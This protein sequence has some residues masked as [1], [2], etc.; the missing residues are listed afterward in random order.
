MSPSPSLQSF[1]DAWEHQL[2]EFE[3][4]WT[5]E[6]TPDL[7]RF[8]PPDATPDFFMELIRIDV[9]R[10]R[11]KSLPV[12]FNQYVKQ[13]PELTDSPRLLQ[14]LHDLLNHQCKPT[15]GS[16]A[17]T[18]QL[19]S[20]LT[21]LIPH[22][23]GGL[24]EVLLAE[25]NTL[26]RKVAVKLLQSR[27]A[28]SV[29]AQ[30]DFL[31]EAKLTSQLEHPGIVPIHSVGQ[32]RDGRPCYSMRFI[33]G[34]T[35]RQAIDDYHQH[36]AQQPGSA[37]LAFRNLLTRFIAVC[38]T[39]AYAHSKNVI[40]RDIKPENIMLGKFGETIV[41]DWGMA[42]STEQTDASITL[43]DHQVEEQ[44]P[45]GY[46]AGIH[47][48]LGYLSPEQANG[49]NLTSATDIFGLGATFYTILCNRP[50]V[51]ELTRE[52][53]IQKAQA[54][55]IVPPSL[56]REGV[57][58]ALDAICMK[59]LARLQDD[60]YPSA[61]ALAADV[62]LY[63][64]DEPVTVC[65][66]PWSTRFKRTLRKR[67]SLVAVL[68]SLGIVIPIGA[69]VGAW[70][71]ALEQNRTVLSEQTS[72]IKHKTAQQ[73][74][75]YLTRLFQLADPLQHAIADTPG[76]A[77]RQTTTIY[78]ERGKELV[79]EHLHDQPAIRAE[80]LEAIGNTYR[81]TGQ[82]DQA[83][84][85]VKESYAIRSAVLGQ[86][87]QATVTSLLSMARLEQDLGN[88]QIA[89][90]HLRE[91]VQQREESLGKNHVLVAEAKYHLG[92]LTFY[93]PFSLEGPQFNARLQKEAETLLLEALKIQ[94]SQ[95]V[96]N[97]YDVGMTLAAIASLKSN[98]PS[99]TLAFF[100]YADKA[101]AAFARLPNAS[102]LGGLIVRMTLADKQRNNKQYDLA[103][104]NY[105]EILAVMKK[106]LGVKHPLTVIHMASFVGL[107]NKRGDMDR[108]LVMAR[109]LME[110]IRPM[111]WFRSQPVIVERMIYFSD[112]VH[113]RGQLDEA[114]QGYQEA[115]KYAQE[116]PYD[117]AG[118]IEA[119]KQRIKQQAKSTPT[120]SN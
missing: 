71:I 35:L 54:A 110:H 44:L 55:D 59:A 48:T 87:N 46:S 16:G 14:K 61:Q 117:N 90:Q 23:R 37:V 27:W 56:Y 53:A 102:P 11:A 108:A 116:R 62:E 7:N 57:P 105:A 103:E 69:A 76:E 86:T 114:Q 47:G 64:A 85:L 19:H 100:D 92:C 3:A 6:Q 79:R 18:V 8:A 32:S 107:V 95:P 80:L 17:N 13:L 99:Q 78:L 40:H 111:P 98:Q 66:E 70:L 9:S 120:G 82:Y 115:L 118:N 94:E 74:T 5:Q 30:H 101:M 22:A 67:K 93:R 43:V 36:A 77:G 58:A 68:V 39:I 75:E 60:R 89:D 29:Q 88:Y 109:E 12:E 83:L 84:E 2:L 97:Y 28:D 81:A 33:E 24:G 38:Q 42:R 20:D 49:G 91:V 1:S 41:L 26:D 104:K 10:R 15:S 51:V 31:L 25:D 21:A 113:N 52:L 112:V 34:Q 63:L 119:L 45:N 106:H 65:K 50:P 72:Q 96:I 4:A 73:I